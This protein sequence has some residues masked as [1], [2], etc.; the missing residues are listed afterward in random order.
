MS[1]FIPV[2]VVTA[3][4]AAEA[5][6][7]TAPCS[8][9]IRAAQASPNAQFDSGKSVQILAGGTLLFSVTPAANV[10]AGGLI[11][12][13]ASASNDSSNTFD[14]GDRIAVSASS[15]DAGDMTV[16]LQLDEFEI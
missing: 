9:K 11:T 4:A 12:L 10:A 6:Y 8:C 2:H 13:A 16:M 14:R 1:L 5:V 15:A 7:V 3:T